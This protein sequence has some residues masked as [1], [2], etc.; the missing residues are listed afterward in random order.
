MIGRDHST[1]HELDAI[2]PS[3]MAG[4]LTHTL[5]SVGQE[6][7]GSSHDTQQFFQCAGDIEMLEFIVS[8]DV[9]AIR[10]VCFCAKRNTHKINNMHRIMMC[11]WYAVHL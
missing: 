10:F 11:G 1:F 2:P 5:Q 7:T 6:K 9:I 8:G 3:Y 4:C